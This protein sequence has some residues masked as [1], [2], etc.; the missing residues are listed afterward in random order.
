MK[1]FPWCF[2]FGDTARF[3]HAFTF[4][5]CSCSFTLMIKQL[6]QQNSHSI[7][8]LF[9]GIRDKKRMFPKFQAVVIWIRIA[10]RYLAN[11]NRNFTKILVVTIQECFHCWKVKI[12]CWITINN[13]L[14]YEPKQSQYSCKWQ[15]PCPRWLHLTKLTFIGRQISPRRQCR[16]LKYQHKSSLYSVLQM[17]CKKAILWKQTWN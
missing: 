8:V 13:N 5:L 14:F 9:S 16:I 17:F 4:A 11:T 10:I 1:L 2:Y 3:L 15:Y 7:V 12:S 6:I